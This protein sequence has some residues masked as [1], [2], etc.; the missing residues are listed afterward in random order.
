MLH[1]KN[2]PLGV[3]SP[4]FKNHTSVEAQRYLEYQIVLVI[5]KK[6]PLRLIYEILSKVTCNRKDI[7]AHS[8]YVLVEL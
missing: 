5:M 7:P 4:A 1:C 6:C 3:E 2:K 8:L